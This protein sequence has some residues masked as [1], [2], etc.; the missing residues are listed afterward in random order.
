MTNG[1]VKPKAMFPGLFLYARCFI[2]GGE[3][4]KDI[5]YFQK[6]EHEAFP[7]EKPYCIMKFIAVSSRGLNS[8]T[9]K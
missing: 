1:N 3:T 9:V 5:A 2:V 4:Q 6:G 7:E 8:S